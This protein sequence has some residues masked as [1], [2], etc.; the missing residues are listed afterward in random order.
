MF[1][2]CPHLSL[3]FPCPQQFDADKPDTI[4]PA[5]RDCHT[6]LVVPPNTE[7]R[8]EL[9]ASLI[10]SAKVHGVQHIVLLAVSETE[11]KNSLFTRQFAVATAAV[12]DS[13]VPYTIVEAE[14]FQVCV[15]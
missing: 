12:R 6:L 13:G 4:G 7:N 9:A 10:N 1:Y 15:F 3:Y 5:L 2:R 11:K 8:G 14:F